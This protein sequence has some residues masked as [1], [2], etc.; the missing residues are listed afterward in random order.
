MKQFRQLCRPF[1]LINLMKK[2]LT[3]LLF[4]LHLIIGDFNAAAQQSV[5]LKRGFLYLS[6]GYNRDIYSKSTIRFQNHSSDNYDFTF[7]DA[8]AHDKP[9]FDNIGPIEGLTIPQYNL[10]LG[11]L[12]NKNNIGVELSWDH[13]KYVVTDFQIMRVT[14]QIRGRQIDKD[15]LVTPDFVHLQHTNGNNYLMLNLV[16]K[17]SLIKQKNCEL[18][19]FSKAG[20]GILY[21]FTISSILG[22]NDPGHFKNQGYVAGI[23]VGP[24][25]DFCKYFFLQANMQG[26]FANYT[27]TEIGADR[28][29]KVTHHFFS[30][31]MAL[32]FG[33]NLP[34][35]KR[36]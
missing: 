27:S 13:L 21:T 29:G 24:R 31:Y 20:I 17:H 28:K 6:W 18:S 1:G 15:T 23:T 25:F 35:G 16:K 2:Y 34:L 9:D 10:H 5:S 4:A 7:L 32:E 22:S 36:L 8:K 30:G 33:F 26:A 12:L 3:F 14:G 11:Y 19:L